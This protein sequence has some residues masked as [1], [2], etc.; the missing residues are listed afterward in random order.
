MILTVDVG[1]SNIVAV[2]YGKNRQRIWNTRHQTIK[3]PQKGEYREFFANHKRRSEAEIS[4]VMISCVVPHIFDI[5]KR[6]AEYVFSDIPVAFLDTLTLDDFDVRLDNPREVGA[7]L[8]ATS[9]GAREYPQPVI[10]ADLGSASK[11]TAVE[12][13]IFYG[14]IIML[15]IGNMAS[16]LHLSIPHLPKIPL[17]RP[18][19][20]I[21]DDTIGSIQSGIIYGAFGS[22]V[23][24]ANMMEKQVGSPCKRILTG[25]YA[26]LFSAE[27]IEEA[28]FEY[29]EF[30]LSDGLYFVMKQLI[31]KNT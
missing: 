26:K 8:L 12:G 31:K 13:N 14:G 18:E 24:L 22:V 1:N 7:D 20:V 2:L 3:K 6:A 21:T 30:L 19:K 27:M 17:V 25:G 23:Q 11:L 5:V 28:G 29:N 10:V 15:G 9:Y 16:A 4:G